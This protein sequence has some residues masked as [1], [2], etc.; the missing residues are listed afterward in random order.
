MHA[1]F[2]SIVPRLTSLLFADSVATPW[3][4][5]GLDAL[6]ALGLAAVLTLTLAVLWQACRHRALVRLKK[7]LDV[8]A[9]REIARRRGAVPA[10][11]ETAWGGSEPTADGWESLPSRS[12]QGGGCR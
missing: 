8:Y 7:A 4:P 9:E 6:G 11:A 2:A 3:W 12:H 5:A 1:P 10:N